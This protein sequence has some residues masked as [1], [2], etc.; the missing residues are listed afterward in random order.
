MVTVAGFLKHPTVWFIQ[1]SIPSTQ[2]DF[3]NQGF[4]Y[5]KNPSNR[6]SIYIYIYISN[7]FVCLDIKVQ[8]VSLD[9]SSILP[10]KKKKN[11]NHINHSVFRLSRAKSFQAQRI[12]GKHPNSIFS[13]QESNSCLGFMGNSALSLWGK[14]PVHPRF[15]LNHLISW[16]SWEF[17][18]TLLVR[19]LFG[20]KKWVASFKCQ[21]NSQ[22]IYIVK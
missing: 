18:R 5:V 6:T 10:N 19:S 14:N 8:T 12:N 3:L 9:I 20:V 22:M 11:I 2:K 17:S 1:E 4:L 15:T 21:K 16:N 7:K 13:F